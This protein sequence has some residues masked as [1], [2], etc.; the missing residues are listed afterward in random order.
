[1]QSLNAIPERLKAFENFENGDLVEL[2]KA[3]M[4]LSEALYPALATLEVTLRNAI[5]YMLRNQFGQD[6]LFYE[7]EKNKFLM[8]NDHKKLVVAFDSLK[9]RKS[10]L[11]KGKVIAELNLSFWVNI[12]SAKYNQVLWNCSKNFKAVFVNYPKSKRTQ[13]YEIAKI[14]HTVKRLRNRIFHYEPIYKKG[15]NLLG[16]YN[17]MLTVLSYL[18]CCE[19]QI[20][21]RTCRFKDVYNAVKAKNAGNVPR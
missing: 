5:D 13:I 21:E 6:W 14:L 20:F 3:N 16:I 4:Q 17:D 15:E 7:V 1:M 10:E 12:C 9:S 8:P 19:H 11:T 2:Y 18:P